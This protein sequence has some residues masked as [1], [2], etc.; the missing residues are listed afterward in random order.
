MKVKIETPRV[1]NFVKVSIG[2]ESSYQPLTV[3]DDEEIESIADC[4][5]KALFKNRERQAKLDKDQPSSDEHAT[6]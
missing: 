6:K 5:K 3:L 2:D 1:P 4:W